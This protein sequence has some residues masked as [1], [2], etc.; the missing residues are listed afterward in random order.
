RASD[1]KAVILVEKKEVKEEGSK[2]SIPQNE[3]VTEPEAGVE[4]NESMSGV[5]ESQ[6][7]EEQKIPVNMW[8]VLI[9]LVMA[10][11]V[12]VGMKRRCR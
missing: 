7:E 4:A 10:T 1:E 8:D 12:S 3:S 9:A 11:F 2:E 6:K 5:N